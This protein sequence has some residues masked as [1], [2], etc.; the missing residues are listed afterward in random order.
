MSIAPNDG[1]E[2]AIYLGNA[3]SGE[4]LSEGKVVRINGDSASNY[5]AGL[6]R[7]ISQESLALWIDLDARYNALFIRRVLP[8]FEVI[9]LQNLGFFARRD[10]LYLEP[11]ELALENGTI[12]SVS[13]QAKYNWFVNAKDKSSLTAPNVLPFASL[14]EYKQFC[15]NPDTPGNSS[16]IPVPQTSHGPR[17]RLA[18]QAEPGSSDDEVQSPLPPG[19][20]EAIGKTP[21]NEAAYFTL[22]PNVGVIVIPSFT[23]S[24]LTTDD[25][26]QT[27]FDDL[28]AIVNGS[29]DYFKVQSCSKVIVDLTGNP[30]GFVQA[31]QAIFE[32]FFP[33]SSSYFAEN[34][35][36]SPLL[37]GL[38]QGFHGHPDELWE[39]ALA[40]DLNST[41]FSQ[42]DGRPFN[43]SGDLIGPVQVNRNF[44]T[45]LALPN[46]RLDLEVLNI[47]QNPLDVPVSFAPE[48]ILLLSDSLCASACAEFAYRMSEQGVRSVVY[49]GRGSSSTLQFSGGARGYV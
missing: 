47:P 3:S 1:S 26:T 39:R 31:Q 27:Y 16:G 28:I 8:D 32:L 13:W 25:V 30:G 29:L 4:A 17:L 38:Y 40:K 24:R 9:A 44:F 21:H 45:S 48:N 5:L 34:M 22:D 35:R 6:A 10:R 43:Q 2:P 33:N 49:G 18:R 15:V 20:P 14:D 42:T 41:F 7:E 12:I 11:L 46:E 23:T 36:Y 19:Y 37:E